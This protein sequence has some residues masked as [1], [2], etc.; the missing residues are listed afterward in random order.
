MVGDAFKTGHSRTPGGSMKSIKKRTELMDSPYMNWKFHLIIQGIKESYIRFYF[1]QL[2]IFLPYTEFTTIVE[3]KLCIWLKYC[4][5]SQIGMLSRLYIAK[6]CVF[7]A[8]K[9][10]I[11]PNVAF[12]LVSLLYN[13]KT[14]YKFS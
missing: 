3:R 2:I 13:T 12:L 6:Q 7:S 14:L 10:S 9:L 8:D 1:Y 11:N 4:N 5:S